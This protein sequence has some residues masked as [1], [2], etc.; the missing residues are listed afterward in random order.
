MN[1]DAPMS[2]Y[3]ED[4]ADAVIIAND[5]L[6]LIEPYR[7]NRSNQDLAFCTYVAMGTVA[8]R[9][10]NDVGGNSLNLVLAS[11]MR[12]MSEEIANTEE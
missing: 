3:D 1:M 2:S 9:L 5:I 7:T 10:A 6:K 12:A 11:F 4:I 8:G